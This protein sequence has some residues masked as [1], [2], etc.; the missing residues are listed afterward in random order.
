MAAGLAI[1]GWVWRGAAVAVATAALILLARLVW[2]LD[3]PAP[4]T[5]EPR[6]A[7][8]APQTWAGALARADQSLAQG[9]ELARTR[10]GEWLVQEKIA[11]A[12]MARARLTGSFDDYAIAD[13]ALAR[14][15][16]TAPKGGGPLLTRAV[17]DFSL[18]RLARAK[19]SLDAIDGYAVKAEP[20]IGDE[21]QAM[22]GDI[23][24]YRGD[25]AQALAQYRR[26]GVTG[27]AGAAFRMAVYQ[28]KTGDIDAALVAI[29]AMAR[30]AR[31][32]TA[33]F[34]AN[35]QLQRGGLELQRGGWGAAEKAFARADV[36]FPGSWLIEAH[37]AQML[38]LSGNRSDAIARLLVIAARNPGPEVMDAL[39][40][41]YRA[42]GDYPNS[43]LWADQAG[44]RW[45]ARLAQF[46]EA[47]Y[48][49]VVEHELA[50]GDPARALDMA[51]RDYSARP[52]A[53]SAIALGWACLA[54]NQP[55]EALR[56]IR[57][58]LASAWVSPEQHLVAAQAYLLL[59]DSEAADAEKQKA[60]A[61]N[62]RAADPASAM[63][64]FGHG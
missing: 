8:I 36:I 15:F 56:V 25:Y 26:S 13:A 38:A 33:Q 46:P 44:A 6:A 43:R 62:P 31:F 42:Q 16:Q 28:G 9:R 7:T 14:A 32:P 29:D 4:P 23:A 35:L 59:G 21:A 19:A 30:T 22:R 47:A 39:A 27:G 57:P 53:A 12:A 60:L 64:W 2:P 51:R 5:P 58:V 24:F 48:G 3:P 11:N 17:L 55:A 49:H 54:N 10:G 50:F 18:H 20:E 1:N 37:R 61:L 41:L 52:Y 45:T 63:I 34:L 40:G